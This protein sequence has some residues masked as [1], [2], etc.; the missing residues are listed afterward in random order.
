MKDPKKVHEL[1][2][3]KLDMA[4]VMEEYGVEFKHSPHIASEVQFKCPFHG[5]DNKPSA[6]LYNTTKSCFC[7]VCRKAW[8][9][10][11]FIMEQESMG[12]KQALH[13][14]PNRYRVDL[15]SIPDDPTIKFKIAQVSNKNVQMMN[16][17][18]NILDLRKNIPLEK[19][20]ILC[21]VFFMAKYQDS[22]GVDVTLGFQKLEDKLLCLKQSILKIPCLG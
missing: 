22:K 10:V 19:Y 15:S 7:W 11:S 2:V 1:I 18:S 20:K 14:I 17:K 3:E 8:D 4:T 9:V 6:R 5:A 16:L 21:A 12:Y 13:Y